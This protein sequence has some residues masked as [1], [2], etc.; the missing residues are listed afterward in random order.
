[1][2][3][4]EVFYVKFFSLIWRCLLTE[5]VLF[6]SFILITLLRNAV[7]KFGMFLAAPGSITRYQNCTG[8][9]T[10]LVLLFLFLMC[11]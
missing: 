10:N 11:W 9:V 5:Y 6:T 3:N 2:A 4:T 7:R 8:D 1:M